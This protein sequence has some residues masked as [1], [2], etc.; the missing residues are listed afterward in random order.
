MRPLLLHPCAYI[1]MDWVQIELCSLPAVC[2]WIRD[3][4]SLSL[5][6]FIHNMGMT[7]LPFDRFST[8]I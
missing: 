4:T 1:E 6:F 5:S 7:I 3:I 8:I 2:L